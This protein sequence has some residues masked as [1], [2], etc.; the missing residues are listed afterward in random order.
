MRTTQKKP[1]WRDNEFPSNCRSTEDIYKFLRRAGGVNPYGENN[2]LLAIA[3]EVRFLQGGEFFDYPEEVA[4]ADC[5]R[6]EFDA[7]TKQVPISTKI[8]GTRGHEETIVVEMPRG[9]HVTNPALRTVKEMRWV[10]RWPLL[11]G[12]CLLHWEPGAGGCSREWW[13]SWKVPMTDLQ[14]LG[15]WPEKGMYWTFCEGIDLST[16]QVTYATFKEAPPFSWM[17]RAIAQFE[18][19][20]NKENKIA[21]P[22][23]RM[24]AALSEWRDRKRKEYEKGREELKKKFAEITAPILL[25]SSLEAGRIR[26][27]L[28]R[29]IGER[30]GKSIGHVGN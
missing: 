28:A 12:W 27:D 26:E 1:I 10:E 7:E 2:Y 4:A 8:P 16:K 29:R 23:F 25:S 6:L 17:E 15:P 14:C 21:N 30:T 20:R 11:E 22:D 13:E 18:H 3:S 24:L 9:M 5:G 19:N